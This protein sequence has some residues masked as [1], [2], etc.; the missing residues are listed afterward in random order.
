LTVVRAVL[1]GW[2][3]YWPLG[4]V[5]FHF[6]F[7]QFALDSLDLDSPD[8]L[9]GSW[10]PPV[11]YHTA[12]FGRIYTF[13]ADG[14]ATIVLVGIALFAGWIVALLFSSQSR[15]ALLV[16]SATVLG[17]W[18]WCNASA[19]DSFAARQLPW[20]AY[21]WMNSILQAGGILIGGMPATLKLHKTLRAIT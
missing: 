16:F 6:G 7:Y 13:A 9:I 20:S 11:W 14:M 10:A 5:L 17:S 21:F 19:G 4:Y 8:L 1:A 12:R 2:L 15:S 18:I 3:V